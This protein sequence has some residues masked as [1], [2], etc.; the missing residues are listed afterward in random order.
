MNNTR[1]SPRVLLLMLHDTRIGHAADGLLR[2]R[3]THDTPARAGAA[4]ASKSS[5]PGAG[6]GFA[7]VASVLLS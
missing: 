4:E 2:R 7:A 5:P 1:E 6:A 3:R